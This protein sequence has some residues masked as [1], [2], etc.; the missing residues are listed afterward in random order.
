MNRLQSLDI[1][2]EL[3]E[4]LPKRLGAGVS[5]AFAAEE[6]PEAGHQANPLAEGGRRFGRRLAFGH[7]PGGAPFLGGEGDLAGQMGAVPSQGHQVQNPPGDD[8]VTR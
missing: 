1:G 5:V 2:H 4:P 7:P 6:A 8:E 3:H